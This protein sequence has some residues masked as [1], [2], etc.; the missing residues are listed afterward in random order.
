VAIDDFGT[1]QSS[2]SRLHTLPFDKIKLDRSFVQSLD[3]PMVQAI[4]RAMVQLASNFSRT[5][6]AEGIETQQQLDQLSA[7]GCQLGQGYLLCRPCD[8]KELPIEL[9]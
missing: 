4:V 1:G 9:S 7:L 8:L 6:L 3:D 5:L 2:L